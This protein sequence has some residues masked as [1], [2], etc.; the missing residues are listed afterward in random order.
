MLDHSR[1]GPILD[2]N[3]QRVAEVGAGI[4]RSALIVTVDLLYLIRH[5]MH[6]LQVWMDKYKK[7]VWDTRGF[8]GKD[9]GD[10]SLR[11]AIRERLQ[12]KSFKWYLDTVHPDLWVPDIEPLA[13]GILSDLDVRQSALMGG[14]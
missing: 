8:H 11:R 6:G 14:V 10:V 2:R 1:I 5:C 4:F 9:P 13:A 3:D 7:I 12:C